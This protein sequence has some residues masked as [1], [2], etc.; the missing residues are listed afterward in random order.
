MVVP[1]DEAWVYGVPQTYV[2]ALL[3]VDAAVVVIPPTAIAESVMA[4][5]DGLVLSGGPDVAPS[6]YGAATVHPTV[7]PSDRDD[8]ELSVLRAAL[9]REL[10]VLGICRGAQLLTVHFG[11]ALHQHLPDALGHDLHSPGGEMGT[12]RVRF[13]DRTPLHDI[14]GS[15]QILNSFHHQGIADTGE[16]VACAWAEDGLVE[17]VRHPALPLVLG[18]Q[19]HP[20]KNVEDRALFRWFVNQCVER[21][22]GDGA[23]AEMRE[24]HGHRP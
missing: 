12:H 19:W 6:R 10:P 21:H 22:Q 7:T 5:L 1:V 13:A 17:A 20:E 16:M 23:T 18:V 8:A 3:A 14:Y 4:R 11:G 9:A 15:S 2:D 24:F